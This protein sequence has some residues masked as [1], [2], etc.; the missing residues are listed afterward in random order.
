MYPNLKAE[1]A[2]R[3]MS[4][5]DLAEKMAQTSA[6]LSKKLSGKV[7]LTLKEAKRIKEILGVDMSLEELFEEA[8]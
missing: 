5:T 6:N 7:V 2:R 1:M 8:A 4:I 3:N